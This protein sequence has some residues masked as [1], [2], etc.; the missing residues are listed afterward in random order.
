M[1]VE[2]E[3]IFSE[4][5]QKAYLSRSNNKQKLI[6]LLVVQLEADTITRCTSDADTMVFSTVIDDV[7]TGGNLELIAVDTDLL[8]MPIYFW[9][10]L[11]GKITMNSEATK[12]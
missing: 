7:C 6:H 5:S 10:M 4:T 12:K 9:N 2:L 1:S 8:I 11:M 3:S